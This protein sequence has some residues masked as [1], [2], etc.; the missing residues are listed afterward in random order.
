MRMK[1]PVPGRNL[2]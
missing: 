2:G 1:N